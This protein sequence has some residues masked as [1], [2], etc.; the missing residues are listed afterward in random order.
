MP[1]DCSVLRVTDEAIWPEVA[2]YPDLAPELAW[3]SHALG[4]LSALEGFITREERSQF[5]YYAR[6]L[7]YPRR[8]KMH[9]ERDE[10]WL[11]LQEPE[12]GDNAEGTV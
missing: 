5:T 12:T 9:Q 11:W 2:G 1:V 10:Y 6:F 7:D 3:L 4:Q 8:L